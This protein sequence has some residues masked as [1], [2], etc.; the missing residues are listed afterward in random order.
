MQKTPNLPPIMFCTYKQHILE[1]LKKRKGDL[2]RRINNLNPRFKQFQADLILADFVIQ[3]PFYTCLWFPLLLFWILENRMEK[4]YDN[5][6]IL[7]VCQCCT[8]QSTVNNR[9]SLFGIFGYL[10]VDL[11]A[12]IILLNILGSVVLSIDIYFICQCTK[13]DIPKSLLQA[14]LYNLQGSRS[15]GFCLLLTRM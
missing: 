2:Y 4:L 15:F 5:L 6:N 13:K 11:I 12:P 3:D 8:S 7:C 14:I 9:D 1:S 10:L